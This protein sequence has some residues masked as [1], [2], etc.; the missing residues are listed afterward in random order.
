MNRIAIVNSSSFGQIFTQ[1]LDR[2]KEIGEVSF[3]YF[4]QDISGK[5]LAEAL[6]DYNFIIASVSPYFTSEFFDHHPGC[7]IISR[8]GIG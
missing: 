1:H 5:D 7:K 2:L 3:F 6:K 4:P 8:H